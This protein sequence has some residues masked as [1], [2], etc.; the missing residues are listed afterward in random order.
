MALNLTL[1]WGILLLICA[2][3]GSVIVYR[4]GDQ[5]ALGGGALP[6][7]LPFAGAIMLWMM[8]VNIATTPFDEW[9]SA[10]VAPIMAWGMGFPLYFLPG[11]G[12]GTAF[13]YPPVSAVLRLPVA[14]ADRPSTAIITSAI[15]NALLYHIPLIL[16]LRRIRGPVMMKFIALLVMWGFSLDLG[17]LNY[18]AYFV[19]ADAP[20]LGFGLLAM[21][22]LM[23]RSSRAMQ[24]GRLVLAGTFLA[25]S[26]GSKQTMVPLLAV[27]P[28]Y[29][30]LRGGFSPAL[31]IAAAASGWLTALGVISIGAWGI[32]AVR[33]NW[34]T[35][36]AGQPWQFEE[37]GR[38]V[39]FLIWSGTLIGEATGPV[40]AM[41]LLW[42]LGRTESRPPRWGRRII[43]EPWFLP[44]LIAIVMM[45]LAVMGIAKRGGWG[46]SLSL[47]TYFLVAAT[48][49][50][51]ARRRWS[52]DRAM[53][54][55]GAGCFALLTIALALWSATP[56]TSL[57]SIFIDLANFDRN[58]EET[59]FEFARTHAGQVYFPRNPLATLMA[60][61][62]YYMFEFGLADEMALG[63]D[64]RPTPERMRRHIPANMKAIAIPPER[65]AGLA[66]MEM[67]GFTQRVSIP[68]LP[69]WIVFTRPESQ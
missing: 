67:P 44:L 45:P 54:R 33:F 68:E 6:A 49:A 27:L 32:D 13:I 57:R 10:R 39:S 22:M 23:D 69:G 64:H 3:A 21:I 28:A 56:F 47:T 14:M 31:I 17:S 16:M 61:E 36:A 59:A 24:T 7:A 50:M 63:D 34:F 18:S 53:V 2:C 4:R 1:A 65:T 38:V 29:V 25:L 52:G 30:W 19:H 55:V 15:L 8:W 60:E 5:H 9:N 37:R 26:I 43:Y 42:L 20:A 66:R 51:L 40:I 35:I 48:G 58:P 41:G 62:R 12:P 11:E 46:N